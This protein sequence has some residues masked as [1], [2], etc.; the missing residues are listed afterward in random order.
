M[1]R[2]LLLAGALLALAAAALGASAVLDQ[3]HR[4]YREAVEVE[5]PRAAI[6]SLLTDFDGY[7]E[8][9][10]Y[11]TR[12]SGVARVGEEVEL[13]LEPPGEEAES[14]TATVLIVRPR[15]KIEWETRLVVPFP[16]VLDH[17]QIFRVLPLGGNRWRIVSE[18]RFEGLLAPFADVDGERAGLERMIEALAER[19][20]RYFQSSSE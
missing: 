12:A 17:E 6:W 11:I 18:A 5:A 7:A 9:N 19:A 15:R 14:H 8:W 20:P 10:P 3:P 1:A 4:Y 2:A 16:G 13:R